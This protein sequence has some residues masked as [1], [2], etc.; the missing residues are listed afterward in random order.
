MKKQKKSKAAGGNAKVWVHSLI[1]KKLSFVIVGF[2]VIGA[3]VWLARSLT[4]DEV[5]QKEN[6]L[7]P[8]VTVYKSTSCS[9]CRAWVTH[10]KK[11]GFKVSSYDRND[12]DKIKT[13]FGVS[14][15]LA[16][17]HT[18]LVGGYIIEGHVPASDIIQLL[19]NK[20]A[21]VGLTAPGMPKYSP[22]MQPS[23]EQ[24]RGYDVLTFNKNGNTT[25]YK[26]Y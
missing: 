20:P 13:S 17:C 18:A 15:H 26:H 9:C 3:V 21:L 10:L 1:L 23:G 11:E 6:F 8:E 14:P 22:G 4:T 5:I 16:S 2:T 12:I 25:V 24:P 19:Q 7:L